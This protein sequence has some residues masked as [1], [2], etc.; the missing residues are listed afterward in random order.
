[1]SRPA[2][3][4][5]HLTVVQLPGGPEPAYTDTTS[6]PAPWGMGIAALDSWERYYTDRLRAG[7]SL[8]AAESA[9]RAEVA[10]N[11]A[12]RHEARRYTISRHIR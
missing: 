2:I 11:I 10:R 7:L 8:T 12:L 5:D 6:L 4:S 1:M 3:T 9:H